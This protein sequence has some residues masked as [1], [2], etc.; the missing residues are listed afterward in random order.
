L[1]ALLYSVLCVLSVAR[2]PISQVEDSFLVSLDEQFECV[3]LA[4][5]CCRNERE[6]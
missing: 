3:I 1:K 6:V 4:A 5:L 2:Y